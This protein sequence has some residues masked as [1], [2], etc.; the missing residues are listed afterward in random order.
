MNEQWVAMANQVAEMKIAVE[1]V[2]HERDQYKAMCELH[3]AQREVKNVR[4]V[5]HG[6]LVTTT[7]VRK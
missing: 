7:K 2:S 3:D 5:D 4:F 1:A 6:P